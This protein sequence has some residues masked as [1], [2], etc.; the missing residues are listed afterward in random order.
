[1]NPE[2]TLCFKSRKNW[3]KW[4]EKNHDSWE[5]AWLVHYKKSSIKNGI[6]H[7]DGVEEAICFGW[8]DGK[9]KS[10]DKDKFILRY[11]PR[12]K[13]SVWSKINKE[14]AE[15]M[16]KHGRMTKAGLDKIEE[17]KS[18]GFWDS[19]YTNKKRE[20]IPAILKKALLKNKGTWDNFRKFA[21]T[22]RNMYIGWVD[23]AKT[24]ETRTK[25]I[26]EVLKRSLL[27]KKPGIS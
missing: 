11:S 25:R 1:M 6:N 13:K 3:R 21:N 18:S 24:E 27:N 19:A 8:I 7:S 2:K 10:I 22:Y 26:K 17:A 9:L 4:L 20:K 23:G 16:I 14:R 5:E 12:K 15:K